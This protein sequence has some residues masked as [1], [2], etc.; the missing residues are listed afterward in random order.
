[1]HQRYGPVSQKRSRSN[2]WGLL[3]HIRS[4]RAGLPALGVLAVL[5]AVPQL[6]L[7]DVLAVGTETIYPEEDA[8]VYSH[9]PDTNYG[10]EEKLCTGSLDP[11]QMFK[12]R[13]YLKFD[14]SSLENLWIVSAKLY[15]KT[16]NPGVSGDPF[17]MSQQVGTHY[18][19]DDSW[20]ET[21][22][23]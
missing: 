2:R 22:I 4:A 12:S 3:P 14:L 1:M 5:I 8:Y 7:A 15:L 17:P 16:K 9:N 23:T 11:L 6:S 21:T 20:G 10:T 13:S 18:L 19:G